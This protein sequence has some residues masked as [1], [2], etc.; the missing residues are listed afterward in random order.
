M[1]EPIPA[2][3]RRGV[4]PMPYDARA[5]ANVVLDLAEERGLTLTHM[6]VHKVVFY[7]H[8]WHLVETGQPFVKQPFEAWKYGPVLRCV[9]ESLKVAGEDPVT[10]RA[11]KF[12]LFDQRWIVV[13]AQVSS[14]HRE[15][16]GRIVAAYG[17]IHAFEL[18]AMTHAPGGPWDSVYNARDGRVNLGMRIADSEI[19]EH[20]HRVTASTRIGA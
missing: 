6:A 9:W 10:E 12:D 3:E 20:F 2:N 1:S 4:P 16:L 5:V 14:E 15:F 11:A 7:A 17:H 19:R 13:P 8:G 18:S